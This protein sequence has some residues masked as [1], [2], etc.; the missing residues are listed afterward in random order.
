MTNMPRGSSG[1]RH[2]PDSPSAPAPS[3]PP[4]YGLDAGAQVK[5]PDLGVWGHIG[6]GNAYI[7]VYDLSAPLRPDSILAGFPLAMSLRYTSVRLLVLGVLCVVL[8]GGAGHA[9]SIEDDVPTDHDAGLVDGPPLEQSLIRVDS[10]H[11]ARDF[12]AA[13]A[14][15]DSLRILHGDKVPILWRETLV[16]THLATTLEDEDA[17][18]P[19]YESALESATAALT[20]DSTSALA[21]AAKAVAE[22]R[23]ALNAGTRERI[24]R[25]RAVKEHAER[26]LELDST[27]A[28]GH[29]VLGRWHR[30]VDDLGFFKRALVKTVYGGLPDASMEQSVVHLKRAI[31]LEDQIQHHLEL[32]K[33]YVRMDREEDAREELHTVL[34]MPNEHPLDPLH[35]EEARKRLDWI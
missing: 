19:Y 22:G 14:A 31:E 20:T 16:N 1:G 11:H 6:T 17:R 34:M 26:A 15:L 10:L 30:E 25:S 33:T 28:V 4:S 21:H 24:Q 2:G 12:E 32:A 7:L 9:Q 5:R 27:L 29:H 13:L 3:V 18:V 23:V 8:G 35:K